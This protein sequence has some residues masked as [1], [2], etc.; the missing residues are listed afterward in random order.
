MGW[1][2]VLGVEWSAKGWTEVRGLEL[3]ARGGLKY[4][5]WSGVRGVD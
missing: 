3:S 5:G 4:Y 2:E 1:T